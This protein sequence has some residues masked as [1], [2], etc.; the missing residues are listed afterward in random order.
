L[1]K[2]PILLH[3]R[4][5][6]SIF[7]LPVFLF[8]LASV[9]TIHIWPTIVL[10][11]VL[12]LLVYPSSNG[13]N[14][15]Q[16]ND[17]GSIGGIKSPPKVPAQMFAVSM[18][19]DITALLLLILFVDATVAALVLLYILASRAYS[20]RGIRLKKYPVLG[21]VI[22]AFFQGAVVYATAVMATTGAFPFTI[23]HILGAAIGLLL[24]GAGYPLT[25]I[26]QHAQDRA[27][28]VKTLSMMLG[29]RGTFIFS[30][31]M[32]AALGVGL[33][34]F[35]LLYGDGFLPLI[36]MAIA[37]APVGFI[38]TKW[39]F[40]TFANPAEANYENTMKMNKMG[41]ISLNVLFILLAVLNLAKIV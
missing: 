23:K 11:V 26:Y 18:L 35:V 1:F 7:L 33:V 36:I 25:Q 6:F 37:L 28:G 24:I 2:S 40:A 4:F 14:S 22:V 3:L 17:I 5:P 27:D 38:F 16:D 12:H 29:I 30:G 34:S 20:Y 39:M 19:M 8:A 15:L 10:F 9:S 41:G 13:Y 31:V 21:F 32:F